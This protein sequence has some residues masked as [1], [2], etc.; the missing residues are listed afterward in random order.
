MKDYFKN[1]NEIKKN[2]NTKNKKNIDE[3]PKWRL[4][5]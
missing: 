1:W 4:L 5:N 3:K 2:G